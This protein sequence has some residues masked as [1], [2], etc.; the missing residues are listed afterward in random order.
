ML[1]SPFD[2]EISPSLVQLEAVSFCPNFSSQPQDLVGW[3]Y[4]T[5][6]A[7]LLS[8]FKYSTCSGQR[9]SACTCSCLNIHRKYAVQQM[10]LHE[11]LIVFCAAPEPN[12]S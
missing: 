12:R 2:G 3:F 4:P 7:L 11:H 9:A 1:D 6:Q 5:S 8:I 10:L